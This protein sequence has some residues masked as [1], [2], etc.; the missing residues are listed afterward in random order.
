[1]SKTIDR[2]PDTHIPAHEVRQRNLTAISDLFLQALGLGMINRNEGGSYFDV[3][4]LKDASPVEEALE[5]LPQASYAT[6]LRI[7]RH[8][9]EDDEDIRYSL[10]YIDT[11][12]FDGVD[13]YFGKQ[14]LQ[15]RQLDQPVRRHEEHFVGVTGELE[16]TAGSLSSSEE[17]ELV[18]DLTLA[19][20]R[21]DEIAKASAVAGVVIANAA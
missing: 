1:M 18:C 9:V 21:L 5:G 13:Y 20:K 10:T 19:Q 8:W 4:L 3:P 7:K 14:E 2:A 11:A 15:F 17:S 6:K 12:N 16:R